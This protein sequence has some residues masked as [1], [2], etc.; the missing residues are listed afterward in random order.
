M[1]GD[2]VGRCSSIKIGTWRASPHSTTEATSA[3][4][5][6]EGADHR[7]RQRLVVDHQDAEA[8]HG[9]RPR[10]NSAGGS[11]G[12]SSGRWCRR[13]PPPSRRSRS[14]DVEVL[15]PGADGGHAVPAWRARS[16]PAAAR[17][18]PSRTVTRSGAGHRR[19]TPA[20]SGRRGRRCRG[21]RR[22]R[23]WWSRNAGTRQASVA[24]RSHSDLHAVPE[25]DLL[26]LDVAAGEAQLDRHGVTCDGVRSMFARISSPGRAASS[27]P[28]RCPDADQGGETN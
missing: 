16:K 19:A 25:A 18:R 22:S 1:S 5:W 17:R 20:G 14:A 26:Q 15:Q 21:G 13:W 28:G 12:R 11:G 3:S 4:A 23:D 7:S 8:C 27:G 10:Q 9:R 6:D 2:D 24:D